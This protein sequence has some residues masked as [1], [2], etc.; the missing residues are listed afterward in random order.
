M[1]NMIKWMGK[2][3]IS[4]LIATVL[5]IGF[6]VALASVIFVWGGGF[7]RGMQAGVSDSEAKAST[8]ASAIIETSDIQQVAPNKMK[9][10]LENTGQ[11]DL[12]SIIVR[13]T[14]DKGTASVTKAGVSSAGK[15]AY[16]A[17]FVPESVG[18][19][20]RLE[21]IPTVDVNKKSVSCAPGISVAAEQSSDVVSQLENWAT[22]CGNDALDGFE[23]CDGSDLNGQNCVGLGYDSGVLAC[24]T[25]YCTFDV[26]GC[27]GGSATC[28]NG[29]LDVDEQC[30]L[31][32]EIPVPETTTCESLGLGIGTLSCTDACAIDSTG[33]QSQQQG[34]VCG[35]NIKEEGEQ[36]DGS[37]TAGTSCVSLGLGIGSVGCTP[38]CTMD[39]SSCNQIVDMVSGMQHTCVLLENGEVYCWGANPYGQL[40]DGNIQSR[41]KPVKA[42]I[43]GATQI[44][45]GDGYTC[46][47]T[48]SGMYCWGANSNGQLGNGGTPATSS[49]PVLVDQSVMG[50]PSSI[51][52]GA[53]DTCAISGNKLYCWGANSFGLFGTGTIG[54]QT[55]PTLSNLQNPQKVAIGYYH[56]CAINSSPG[57]NVYCS[58]Y[59]NDGEL[60]QWNNVVSYIYLL[61]KNPYV[62]NANSVAA[63]YYQSFAIDGAGKV[64]YWGKLGSQPPSLPGGVT[65][66]A[67]DSGVDE[68]C[69]IGSDS[70]LY[71]GGQNQNGEVT[72]STMMASPS[73]V[74][75]GGSHVCAI[76]ATGVYCWG[77]GIY[78]QLGDGLSI[79]QP[80]PVRVDFSTCGNNVVEIN[81]KCDGTELLGQTC[82]TQ[83]GFSGGTL[84]CKAACNAFDVSGCTGPGCG[85]GIIEGSEQCDGAQLGGKTC[86][87]VNPAT[88]YGALG[89]SPACAYDT[90]ACFACVPG[91]QSGCV[92]DMDCCAPY[93]CFGGECVLF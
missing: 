17:E 80:A 9:F 88:P 73:R 91:G 35:N 4:P 63:S 14:G 34:P 32:A 37:D 89:C 66:L 87:T 72:G 84:A 11:S 29:V 43:S 2:R 71:C 23:E 21:I 50:M 41:A 13:I 53:S 56:A 57:Y 40:G 62:S 27:A 69:V 18:V 1:D 31:T 82:Q 22:T 79:N 48:G 59:N 8:C 65:A 61:T 83:G 3:G 55:R 6:T 68:T 86:A 92:T 5:I 60:G 16:E 47:L 38:S 51:Y 70:K 44:V 81:E 24:G 25:E 36:C 67:I 93:L 64:W 30:D 45:A 78:S 77:Q 90:S 19:I 28:G 20:N 76:N 39:S 33:C 49:V 26:S 10:L 75:V 7:I 54:K 58:G 12:K 46:A 42:Q 74:S 15:K 52:A 85:N